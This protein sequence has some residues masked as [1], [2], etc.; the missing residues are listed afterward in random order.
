MHM[1]LIP[2]P[3]Y[4]SRHA[5][6]LALPAEVFMVLPSHADHARNLFAA[7]RFKSEAEAL[8]G[9]RFHIAMGAGVRPECEIRV[10]FDEGLAA[11]LPV[12]IRDQA[13]WLGITKSGIQLAARA[14]AGLFYAF[15]TL[16]QIVR[17]AAYEIEKGKGT[18]EKGGLLRLPRVTVFDHP[19][20]ARRGVYHDTARG[21]VPTVDTLLQ[22]IDDL[23]HLKYNEFQLYIENN[24][25]FRRHPEMYDDTDPYTAEELLL[26]DAACRARHMDFVPSLTSLGHFEKILA[27]PK[28]RHLAEAEPAELKAM[29][30]PCWHEAGPW[31]LCVTNPGARKLLAEM[32]A[33]FAP[34]F[35]SAQFN[36]CCDEAY[37]LGRGRSKAL[38]GKPGGGGAGQMYVDWINYCDGLVKSH[39]RHKSIQMWG[40]II[41]KY[42]QLIGQ[43]PADAT[44]LE[45][46]YEAD[47]AFEEHCAI[48]AERLAEKG[49]GK[50]AKGKRLGRSGRG[51][52]VA[53]GTSSWLSF[54]GRTKNAL[55][56]IHAAARAGLKHGAKGMLVT[57][58]GDYGHQQM[59]AASL[60]PLG[61]GAAAG[62]NLGETPGPEGK[63]EAGSQKTEVGIKKVLA[64]ISVHLFGDPSAE[65]AT[66][67]YDLGLTYERLGWQR[68]NAS[69]DFFLF[70]E[71]WEVAEFANRAT[72]EG[73]EETMAAARELL[74]RFESAGSLRPDGGEIRDEFVFTCREIIHTCRRTLVRKQWLAARG[75]T[76]SQG[77][78]REIERLRAEVGVLEAEFSRL[79]LVRN[80]PS[81][82]RDVIAEFRRLA[83]EYRKL[84][85]DPTS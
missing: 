14:P 40:D 58:W 29:G 85:R 57:D 19:D 24:F 11:E 74:G 59:L 62:W 20:F 4:L 21:K 66:L 81:R 13:Y 56:N 27:R 37:D 42:P 51:F 78:A 16:L 44:L 80:K 70:R 22:L 77:M 53:P 83:G 49:K 26:L 52:Y 63:Q 75:R 9:S 7:E 68:K 46:G 17:E 61:Y 8:S 48:F 38:V 73:L 50:T 84:G 35:S 55:G 72:V 34:N 15:Q 64:G 2:T 69:L 67:A 23:A 5:G 12:E 54:A 33:E 25:Q 65:F 39:G 82:M 43:L 79:W 71:Q 28:Y 32:Y 60:M 41:L 31:S 76:V 1:H 30:V 36:I 3:K 47:H 6:S 10:V 18:M 45:W